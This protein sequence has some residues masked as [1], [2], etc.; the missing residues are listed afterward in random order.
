MSQDVVPFLRVGAAYLEIQEEIDHA[1]QRVMDS[2]LYLLGPELEDFERD[3]SLYCGA[4]A[5][6]GVGNGLDALVLALKALGVGPGDE[7][8]VPSNTFIAT[9]LA[10]S[11]VGAKLVPVEPD[12][13]SY[14]V[15]PEAIEAAITPQ[16]AAI[17]PV[18]LYGRPVDARSI[19]RIAWRYDLPVIYDAAQAHGARVHERGVGS[20]GTV[21]AWSFY[22]GKNLGAH[23][24]AGAI[25]TNDLALANSIRQLRNYGSTQK[26]DHQ[27]KGINSRMD[28]LQAAVLN[29]KLKYLD[30]WNNRRV[31]LADFYR[32][33]LESTSLVLPEVLDGFD[34]VWHLFVVRSAE[35]DVLQ[36]RL[37]KMGIQ[38]GVHYRTPPHKQ[39]AYREHA[40]RK[41]PIAELIADEVLS[42]PIGP[43]LPLDE[44]KRVVKAV[45]KC[46]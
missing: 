37:L 33:S 29:A 26:Y 18:H 21:T 28:E 45:H 23:G 27:V 2:G 20:F 11:A 15:T 19:D 31:L 32:A 1:I 43:H 9:W 4:K 36:E 3:W 8:L 24:D 6:V 39:L 38:T 13:R 44:A 46:L 16:T 30:E 17:M 22:P 25:T 41:L 40:N 10:V 34:Q 7:V 35:R 12:L 42:L 5:C 14:N